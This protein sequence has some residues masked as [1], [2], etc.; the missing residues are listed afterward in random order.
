MKKISK[1][2]IIL[3]FAILGAAAFSSFAVVVQPNVNLTAVE[4]ADSSKTL[5]ALNCARCHGTDGK[6]QT[7]LGQTLDVPD[8]TTDKSSVTR[9]T[10]VI[11]NGMGDMPAFGK[12][13]KKTEITTLAKYV[14][15]L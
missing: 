6:G 1:L 4:T 2:I 9:N 13:L 3:A 12:K 15:S 10:K 5:F 8:L 7:Q 11:T 14:R